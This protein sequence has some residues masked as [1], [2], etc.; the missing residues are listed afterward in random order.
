LSDS[1]QFGIRQ[2]MTDTTTDAGLSFG[3]R[4]RRER[5]RIVKQFGKKL[6]R[7]LAD[8]LGRQSLVGNGAVLENAHFPFLKEFENN[9]PAIEREVREILK[10][11]ED[12][13]VFQDVSPDQMRIARG[14][15]WRTF[16]L[17]G[18]GSRL[19]KNC[20]QAPVTTSLLS[21]VPNIQS[22]WFSILGP[23]YHIPAHRGVTKGIVRAHM[24][25]IIPK[26]SKNCYMRIGDHIKVWQQGEVFVFDD[27]YVHEVYNNTDDDRVI[28][29]FDFDRPMSLLGR[30]VSSSFLSLMKLT[31]YY[32]EPKKNM[33]DFEE[34]F[35]AATRR[36]NENFEK[37]SD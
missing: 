19:E 24:G 23:N 29:L 14:T 35:E 26:D 21:Q 2:S 36:N 13:P 3:E 5:R 20:K 25:L 37:L 15:N 10:F 16:I 8:F 34:R 27:T 30:M 11:R 32:Q 28:L 6:I 1:I 33:A 4:F 12:I 22:A 31:A 18:F 7:G 9:W 17:Y